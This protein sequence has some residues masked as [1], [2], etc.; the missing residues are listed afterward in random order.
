MQMKRGGALASL[1]TE[2]II[3]LRVAT[4]QKYY[5]FPEF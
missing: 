3:P 1:R 5:L 2:K 4:Y